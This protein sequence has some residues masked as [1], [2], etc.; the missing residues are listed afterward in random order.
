MSPGLYC[1]AAC[2]RPGHTA[3]L[4]STGTVSF[5]VLV[6]IMPSW[7][8]LLFLLCPL[9]SALGCDW[10]TH[11]GHASNISR[12]HA[13]HMGG[14]LTKEECPVSFPYKLYEQIRTTKVESQLVFIRDSLKLIFGLYRHNNIS[15]VTWDTKETEHFLVCVYR[16][17]EELD[18]CVSTTMPGDVK[19]R[20]YYRR[21]ARRTLHCTGGSA[22]SWELIRKETIN[23][24][25]QLE[26]LVNAIVASTSRRH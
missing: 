22:E 2:W 21:L 16:Q 25:Q 13:E 18:S 4:C 6:F 11:Y 12:T 7:T 19:L 24:L 10:L 14:Q 17:I 5:T 9:T 1:S 3:V 26:L 23:H 15:S 20:R 8:S